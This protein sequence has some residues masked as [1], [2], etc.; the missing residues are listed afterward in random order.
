MATRT[1]ITM[2]SKQNGSSS[3]NSRRGSPNSATPGKKVAIK[4]PLPMPEN[5][6]VSTVIS[7]P[8]KLELDRQENML[9]GKNSSSALLTKGAHKIM[10]ETEL[11]WN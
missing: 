4:S 5:A 9:R 11:Y 6:S 3:P 2:H 7:N 8:V 10:S 1:G